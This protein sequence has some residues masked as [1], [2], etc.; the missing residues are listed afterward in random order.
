[1]QRKFRKFKKQGKKSLDRFVDIIAL[2]FKIGV[3]LILLFFIMLF[4]IVEPIDIIGQGFSSS[5]DAVE[6][7]ENM[8]KNEFIET[9]TPHAKKAEE[10]YGTRPSILIAQAALESNWGQSTLSTTSNNYFGIKG[11]Q[12]SRQ[13]AT[14]E[15]TNEEWTEI[16][17]SFKQ[18]DSLSSSIEDYAKLLKNG[19]SW[20]SNFYQEVIHADNYYDA[21]LAIQ[22]AGYA[23][24]P[25]YATKLIRIIEQHE[26]YELDV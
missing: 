24:D 11:A 1:M 9:L 13:Y 15:Y 8:S 7:T 10:V 17:A 18:Y 5:N 22:E 2:S 19:T 3:G 16:N 23:T 4:F 21:A 6:T 26:L 25:E 12:N 14:R 20:D